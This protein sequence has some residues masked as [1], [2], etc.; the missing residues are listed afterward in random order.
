MSSTCLILFCPHCFELRSKPH[1]FCT[2][3]LCFE[4]TLNVSETK[5]T[6]SNNIMG[7]KIQ[8]EKSVRMRGRRDAESPVQFECMQLK[9]DKHNHHSGNGP[10]KIGFQL[11]ANSIFSN[12]Q[13]FCF[14]FPTTHSLCNA[15]AAYSDIHPVTQP[16]L[17]TIV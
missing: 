15:S 13:T 8:K 16:S 5:T 3:P 7:G 9:L 17:C 6:S 1:Q 10:K 2:I 12:A 14:S 4:Y 11:F